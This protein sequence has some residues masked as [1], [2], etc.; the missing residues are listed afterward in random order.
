MVLLEGLIRQWGV[1]LALYSDRHSAFKHN[2]RLAQLTAEPTQFAKMM[3]QLGIRQ[4]FALSPQAKGRVE[5]MASTLQDRLI[6]ELRLTGASTIDQ[7]NGDL[8]LDDWIAEAAF[9]N[10]EDVIFAIRENLVSDAP[11]VLAATPS[12]G[13]PFGVEDAG[14]WACTPSADVRRLL[15]HSPGKLCVVR[16]SDGGDWRLLVEQAGGRWSSARDE[17]AVG[18]IHIESALEWQRS[19][20]QAVMS[21]KLDE[22]HAKACTRWAIT[23][24]KPQG[25][26]DLIG[27]VGSTVLYLDAM[28]ALPQ[29]LTVCN[30]EDLDSDLLSMGAPN[31]VIDLTT[32]QLL[33]TEGARSRFVTRHLPDD[34]DSKAI[35]P[36]AAALVG[37][38]TDVDRDY[39]LGAYGF[40]ARGNPARR[41]YGLAGRKG[42]AK[43]TLQNAIAAAFGDV[44]RNGYAMSMD[45]EALVQSR[46]S[47][48]KQ[49][50]QGNLY[51]AQ[52]ARFIMTEEPPPGRKF[53]AS[54]LKSIS[55]GMVQRWRNVGEKAGASRPVRGTLFIALNHG[56]ED[57][58]DTSDEALADRTRLLQYPCLPEEV[59][60]DP[61]RIQDVANM[62]D[63]RQAVAALV[64]EWAVRTPAPPS[65]PPSVRE[66]TEQRRQD[67][68]GAIGQYILRHVEVTKDR[69]DAMYVSEL[70]DALKAEI[71]VT[72]GKDGKDRYEGQTSG[73]ILSLMRELVPELPRAKSKSGGSRYSGV[74]LIA[75]ADSTGECHICGRR[76]DMA[77]LKYTEVERRRDMDKME[78]VPSCGDS[79]AGS[80]T[81][82]T[83]EGQTQGFEGMGP[84]PSGYQMQLEEAVEAKRTAVRAAL[85]ALPDL[86]PVVKDEP[87]RY[88]SREELEAWPGDFTPAP[89][90]LEALT[91]R[92]TLSRQV[93]GLGKLLGAI[94]MVP[95]GSL[96]TNEEMAVWGGAEKMA[97]DYADVFAATPVPLD[98]FDYAR[99]L[100]DAK[101]HA[102]LTL[103][104]RPKR[105]LRATAA[106]WVQQLSLFKA[107]GG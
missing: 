37:H 8:G 33:P 77:D 73:E 20:S 24:A 61:A 40:A 96:M 82:A 9:A 6:T 99:L 19:V 55:G 64:I 65:D 93:E 10:K 107:Q 53:D 76:R 45:V 80:P 18:K 1:P 11:K 72:P 100:L 22:D 69:S 102:S 7:A 89:I 71:G 88:R 60:K 31:G 66:F 101:R 29:D 86:F 35:H 63:V 75:D 41:L 34:Y 42:G 79:D 46:W 70:L 39:L 74:R 56:Q 14:P 92:S 58:L 105:S 49:A 16:G 90:N 32:G 27:M 2:V 38:L 78:C 25:V 97:E 47:G 83:G 23:S 13:T 85:A 104:A 36:Y 44:S 95:A 68:I 84:D 5:R 21:G 51:G 87:L 43:S 91:E 17:A 106:V 59:T 67:S 15:E 62:R 28:G 26:R 48:G 54:L 52:D 103:A 3:Q 98:Q 4:I 81:G 94:R 12:T 57:A 30:P 50:H